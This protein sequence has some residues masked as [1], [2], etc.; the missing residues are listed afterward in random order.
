M[1]DYISAIVEFTRQE[2]EPLLDKVDAI[3]AMMETMGLTEK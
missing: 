1:T 3:H 2:L